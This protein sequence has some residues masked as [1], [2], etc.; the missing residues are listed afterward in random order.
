MQNTSHVFH[1]NY[2]SYSYNFNP[3]VFTV[4]RQLKSKG[5]G[6]VA[7]IELVGRFI[8]E[9][10][11]HPRIIPGIVSITSDEDTA[12]FEPNY[13]AVAN[14]S[15]IGPYFSRVTLRVYSMRVVA[16]HHS[17]SSFIVHRPSS[18]HIAD[19]LL[20]SDETNYSSSYLIMIKHAL[21]TVSFRSMKIWS[22]MH[23]RAACWV[24]TTQNLLGRRRHPWGVAAPILRPL[25][26]DDG[27]KPSATDQHA[28]FAQEMEELKAEREALFGFTEEEHQA[29]SNSNDHKHEASFMEM[30]EQARR[31]EDTKVSGDDTSLF[32]SPP[33][34]IE[35]EIS[36]KTLTHLT[37]DGKD[38]KMVDVGL[39]DVTRRVA[40]AESKVVFPPEVLEAFSANTNEM[41]GPK[42][43][44]FATAKIA[45][46]MA[47]K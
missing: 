13:G 19:K 44:I 46:I 5:L 8:T 17:L 41:V 40:V 43:P 2:I 21:R 28:L 23:V 11:R 22:Q 34:D 37:N 30:V 39:K 29:W 35:N 42:G 45:G 1:K 4:R 15:S 6:F 33:A 24:A 12:D 31:K 20:I 3:M 9:A 18:P 7:S 14:L 25:S 32:Q 10:R 36:N 26:T 38:V 16:D 27:H 47:A